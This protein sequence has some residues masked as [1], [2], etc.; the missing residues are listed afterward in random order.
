MQRMP[1]S[2]VLAMLCSQFAQELQLICYVTRT[3]VFLSIVDASFASPLLL[4]VGVTVGPS[5]TSSSKEVLDLLHCTTAAA[6]I[7][8]I[9]IAII[10]FAVVLGELGWR[11]ALL[12]ALSWRGSVVAIEAVWG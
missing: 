3:C 2:A 5:S 12:H 10:E 1:A 6:M 9:T 8:L 4:V 11:S 7:V